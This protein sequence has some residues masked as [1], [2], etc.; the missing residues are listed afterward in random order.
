MDE[1]RILQHELSSRKVNISVIKD[2]IIILLYKNYD[3]FKMQ[4]LILKSQSRI[5]I[6]LG[7]KITPDY[8]I[9]IQHIIL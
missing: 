9:D 6:V 7:K 1:F 5:L 8:N 2:K 3:T 4:S